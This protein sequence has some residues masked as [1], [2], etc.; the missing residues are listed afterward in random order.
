MLLELRRPILAWLLLSAGVVA[1]AALAAPER[2]PAGPDTSADVAHCGAVGHACPAPA[3]GKPTCS[4]G[5]CGI[6][7][8]RGFTPCGD[9]CVSPKTDVLHCGAC[10]HVCPG[11]DAP[12]SS[13]CDQTPRRACIDGQCKKCRWYCG[14]YGG[15][16]RVCT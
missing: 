13:Y 4:A 15:Y 16:Y 11:E 7:C 6:A 9:R 5:R 10:G 1:S 3:H 12:S 14:G 2:A 8:D